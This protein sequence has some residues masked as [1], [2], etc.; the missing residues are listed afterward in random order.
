MSSADL[1]I[2]R[3]SLRDVG[4]RPWAPAHLDVDVDF[5]LD[6]DLNLNLDLG[7][8]RFRHFLRN[9]GISPADNIGM[10]SFQ[11]LHV[12][13]RAIEFVALTIDIVEQ[14]PRG[15]RQRADQLIRAAE[16]VDRNIAEGAGRWSDADSAK[17]YKI[18]RGEAM[19][20][21]SSLD[22]LKLRNLVEPRRYDDGIELLESIVAM[23]TKMI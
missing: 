15:H 9:I 21:A 16:S 19:E 11:R 8:S 22:V 2:L 1:S 20:S 12:Y 5:D 10:L 4:T 7:V 6:L 3:S 13:Q 17:H 14:L 18:A 23:L